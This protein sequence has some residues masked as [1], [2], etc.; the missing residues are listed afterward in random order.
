MF[1]NHKIEILLPLDVDSLIPI[2]IPLG[3]PRYVA[4]YTHDSLIYGLENAVPIL[5]VQTINLHSS[6]GR[7][8]KQSYHCTKIQ[9]VSAL[10]KK[11]FDISLMCIRSKGTIF[12]NG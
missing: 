12:K 8:I 4:T 1:E 5:I 11:P 6:T 9:Y 2:T 10:H 7:H 3:F